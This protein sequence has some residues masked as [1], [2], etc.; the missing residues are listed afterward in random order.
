MGSRLPDPEATLERMDRLRRGADELERVLL[1][2]HLLLEEEL[3]RL[4]ESGAMRIQ[5]LAEARLTFHQKLCL[6][7]AL[8]HIDGWEGFAFAGALNKLRNAWAHQA[9]TDLAEGVYQVFR[10]SV[11]PDY[12]MP[13]TRSTVAR[14]LRNQIAATCAFLFG[15]SFVA[16]TTRRVRAMS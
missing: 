3:L 2:G 14:H 15:A 12:K 16:A 9:D 1:K 4:I 8:Y 5:P 11:D 6:A 13:R 10:A 7:R